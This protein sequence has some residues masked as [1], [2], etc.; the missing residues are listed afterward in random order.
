MQQLAKT[1]PY[2]LIIAPETLVL[3]GFSRRSHAQPNI[4]V[5]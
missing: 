4:D 2:L 5:G 3:G 1:A